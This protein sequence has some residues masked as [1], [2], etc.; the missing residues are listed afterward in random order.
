MRSWGLRMGQPL[1]HAC[2]QDAETADW[3][4]VEYTHY[5]HYQFYHT[6]VIRVTSLTI[7]DSKGST[8]TLAE[9][10]DHAILSPSSEEHLLFDKVSLDPAETDYKVKIDYIDF[11]TGDKFTFDGG[12][13]IYKATVK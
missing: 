3:M 2:Y 6:K 5:L 11:N 12:A 9:N 13:N 8:T 4:I 7:V 1:V 10:M